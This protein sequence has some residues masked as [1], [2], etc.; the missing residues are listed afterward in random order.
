[1][2]GGYVIRRIERESLVL[3]FGLANIFVNNKLCVSL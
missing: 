2:L 1:M 3:A